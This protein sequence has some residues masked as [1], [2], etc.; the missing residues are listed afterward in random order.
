[1][2]ET[3]ETPDPEL[4]KELDWTPE[5]LRQFADRWQKTR[6]ME[7]PGVD[8][9]KKNKEIRDALESLGMR[10]KGPK[11]SQNIRGT[12]DEL[13]SIRDSGNRKPAPP[14]YRDIFDAFRRGIGQKK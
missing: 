6:E 2:E 1:M 12:A 13:R 11:D 3:G 5:D 7:R 14:A 10:P 8:P 9:T 4:L